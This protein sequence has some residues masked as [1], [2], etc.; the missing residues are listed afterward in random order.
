M[1]QENKNAESDFLR[2]GMLQKVGILRYSPSGAREG[3]K[4]DR[5]V[6]RGGVGGVLGMEKRQ[7]NDKQDSNHST[8]FEPA[9]L[10]LSAPKG[11]AGWSVRVQEGEPTKKPRRLAWFPL[12]YPNNFEP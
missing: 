3:E 4:K 7:L 5:T 9:A 1:P 10:V 11:R 8:N 12:S 2:E 6:F